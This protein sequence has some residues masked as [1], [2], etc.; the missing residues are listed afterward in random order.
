MTA[1]DRVW[2]QVDDQSAVGAVRR[3]AVS[4]GIEVGLSE[5]AVGDLAIVVTEVATNLARHAQDGV[6]LLRIVRVGDQAGT[7]VV[8]IDRGPGIPDVASASL[9]G[10][11]TAGTLGIGL[12]AIARKASTFAIY[13]HVDS[14]TVLTAT[15]WAGGRPDPWV[16]GLSRPIPGEDVC[17]DGYAAR[18]VNGRR[19]VMLCDGLGHGPL[20][21]ASARAAVAEFLAAPDEGP[22]GVLDHVHAR[23]K[24]TRGVV[25]AVADFEPGDGAVRF[26]GVGNV[27]ATV[28]DGGQRR[29]MVSLP[30]IL[31]QQRREAR[32]FSYEKSPQALL[33]L[34]SDGLTDRWDLATYPGLVAQPPVMVAATLIRD[35][36]KRHDDASVLVATVS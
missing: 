11:S 33:V 14:G 3:S 5:P 13:S 21:A 7:E 19:Q 10:H 17:G 12:G 36:A 22:K 31:G 32:E 16:A 18:T 2:I 35:A 26:A 27:A 8:A 1:D 29:S 20:A 30:G 24:H 4:L 9:D 6:V 25:A 15:V 23:I 34:H 28:I